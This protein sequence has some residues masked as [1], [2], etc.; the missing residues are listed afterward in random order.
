MGGSLGGLNSA[1]YL[2]DIGFHVTVFE[3]STE[4]LA[5]RGAGIVLNPYTV[6]YLADNDV[7]NL[8]EISINTPYLRYINGHNDIVAELDSRYRFASYNSIYAS[9]LSLF[10]TD[11]YHLKQRVTGFEQRGN[12]VIVNTIQGAQQECDLLV[13][14]DGVGSDARHWLL[15]KTLG[16]YSGYIAW[17]GIV[18][19]TKV[20]DEALQLVGDSIIYHILPD[21]HLLTYPIPVVE[22]S[23][24]NPRR[25]INWLWYRNVPTGQLHKTLMTDVDG[26]TR[27]LSVAPGFV[28]DEE[29]DRMKTDAQALP[30]LMRELIE[31][32]EQ[33]FIQAIYDY[34]IPKMVFGQVC[35]LGDA[36]YSVRPHTATGT[37]KAVEDGRQLGIAMLNSNT[38]ITSALQMWGEKQ[39]ILGH[40]LV[41]RNRDVGGKLQGGTWPVGAP[42]AFGLY[43]QGDSEML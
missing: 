42:L 24:S 15:G 3:R 35:V 30:K 16:E 1:L 8:E 21:G 43:A 26:N 36:A 17:R 33:P 2:R 25:C 14:A 11:N 9:L 22:N 10:G 29:I 5:G 37:A 6:R 31:L 4:P 41:G 27:S 38:H 20:S 12:K 39:S 18:D 40:E 19:E 23:I 13:C 28:R 7:L 34:E 32:T